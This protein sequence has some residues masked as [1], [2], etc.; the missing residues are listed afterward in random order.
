MTDR[1]SY[2]CDPTACI[3]HEHYGLGGGGSGVCWHESLWRRLEWQ[4]GESR[5]NT[6]ILGLDAPTEADRRA[7]V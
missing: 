5:A 6:I 7:S 4:Y 2:I 3:H 1:S